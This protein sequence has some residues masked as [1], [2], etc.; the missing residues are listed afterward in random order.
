MHEMSLAESIRGIVEEAREKSPFGRVRTV[1]LALGE[2]AAVEPDSLRFCF[3]A[4]MKGGPAEGAELRIEAVP[5]EGRC[6]ACASRVA[7]HALYEPC[8]ACGAYGVEVT[9]GNRMQVLEL[10]VE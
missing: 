4:V 6:P 2:L 1:V 7:L 8:P 10:E 9:G 5:G 3:D